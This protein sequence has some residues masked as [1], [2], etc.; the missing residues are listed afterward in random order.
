MARLGGLGKVI[1]QQG[2]GITLITLKALIKA[3]RYDFIINPNTTNDTNKRVTIQSTQNNETNPRFACGFPKVENP[4]PGQI[5]SRI[6]S[7]VLTLT[8]MRLSP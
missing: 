4:L 2:V 5:R 7:M 3:L 8:L 1:W 6:V